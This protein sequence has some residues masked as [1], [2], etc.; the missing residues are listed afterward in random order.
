MPEIL[1]GATN[2]GIPF[3]EVLNI[4]AEEFGYK[5][6]NSRF[7]N[8]VK[9][10]F[11][12]ALLD[13]WNEYPGLRR[14][15]VHDAD[16]SIRAGVHTYDVVEDP[17]NGGFGWTNCEEVLELKFADSNRNR[18]VEKIDL[19]TFRWR[20]QNFPESGPTQG[21][22]I[23]DSRRIRIFP[24]PDQNYTAKGDYQQ[25]VPYITEGRVSWPKG[26][27]QTAL[28]GCE[29]YLAKTMR[30]DIAG[31]FREDFRSSLASLRAGDQNK[32]QRPMRAVTTRRYDRHRL[33]PADNSTDMG[34]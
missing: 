14:F 31:N 4:C 22:V 15:V 20:E 7:A 11:N 29:Y 9:R 34:W 6:E 1:G 33:L 27:D 28:L 2:P 18:T 19:E 16:A 17:E 26:W 30:P 5:P 25:T 8:R 10:A 21:F 13:I 24:T 12:R 3:A 32:G 23:V